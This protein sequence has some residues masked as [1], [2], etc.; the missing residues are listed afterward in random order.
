MRKSSKNSTKSVYLSL[1]FL[2]LSVPGCNCSDIAE[3][4]LEADVG[5]TIWRIRNPRDTSIFDALTDTEFYDVEDALDLEDFKDIKLDVEDRESDVVE[6]VEEDGI[7]GSDISDITDVCVPDCNGKQCGDD[8]CGGFCGVCGGNA[9]CSYFQC[10]CNTGFDNC[11]NDWDNGCEVNFNDRTTCGTSCSNIVNCGANSVCNSGSC[12][13]IV[14]Y[15]DC[16]GSLSD[17]CEKQGDIKHLWSNRFG[18]GSGDIGYS[19]SIDSLGDV[20]I[21][22][23]FRS[24]TIDLGG[25]A[26]S[27]ANNNGTSDI[28]LARYDRNGNHLWSKGFGGSND[29][30]VGSVSI[31]NSGNTY[32][33]GYFGSSTIDFGGG[34]LTNTNANCVSYLCSDIFLAKFDKDGN[35]LWSKRFG[36]IDIE[37][38]SSVSV[39]SLGSVYITGSFSSYII[40][41]GGSALANAHVY[42]S[43]IF[44]SKFD[45]NGNHLWSKRFGGSS[46][47]IGY[48]VS[49]DSSGNV[50]ITGRF[51]S[52]TIDFGGDPL[53][54]K[55]EYDI[56]LAKFDKDG[57]HLWSKRF[58]GI[59]L[60]EG[61]S[62]SVDSSGNVYITGDFRSSTID[63]GG[64]TLTNA[65]GSDIFLAKFDK[66]GNHLWSK[67]FGGSSNDIGL[68]L[69]VD[70]SGNV[71][72]T[73]L[74]SGSNIVFGGCPLTSAGGFDIFLIKYTP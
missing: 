68:S 6:N 9:N 62:V 3:G 1:L 55:G 65:G 72:S 20:S 70:S 50:Y 15:Y 41:F 38:G 39:D 46:E 60:D 27:N 13:C 54:N 31:D 63:F 66:D 23:R 47:D 53:T 4:G 21:T 2:I 49:V 64:G 71:Y 11:D 43:D 58:G 7:D 67:R 56:F 35:H 12:G 48:S 28:F 5:H 26:L 40:E 24:S 17:G 42:Y 32:I 45:S 57:N 16:N 52:S 61:Y 33:T 34:A 36:G 73:G 22:G 44:L 10:I 19:I 18:G 37:R 14:G 69:S 59:N 51:S 25:G 30:Y 8:G 29:D 74:F